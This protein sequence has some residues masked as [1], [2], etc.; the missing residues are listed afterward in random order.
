MILKTHD[1]FSPFAFDKETQNRVTTLRKCCSHVSSKLV[2]LSGLCDLLR[3]ERKI[4]YNCLR[5]NDWETGF[6]SGL[7]FYV[8]LICVRAALNHKLQVATAA[9]N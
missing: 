3:E 9:N 4:F 6:V 8:F 7:S 1:S 2:L 5:M